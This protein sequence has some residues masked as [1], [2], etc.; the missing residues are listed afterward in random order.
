MRVIEISDNKL[1][2]MADLTEEMLMAGGKL[3]SCISRREEE[4]FGERRGED[5]RYR[6][7]RNSDM[8]NRYGGMNESHADRDFEHMMNERRRGRR[9]MY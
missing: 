6:D 9:M 3:M 5:I 8:Y 7:T 1:N 2:K 4:M